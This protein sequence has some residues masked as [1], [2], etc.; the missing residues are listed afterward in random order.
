MPEQLL[1]D[2]RITQSECHALRDIGR[3]V[4]LRLNSWRFSF[5]P[6]SLLPRARHASASPLHGATTRHSIWCS[7]GILLTAATISGEGDQHTLRC[8]SLST[9][10]KPAESSLGQR[11]SGRSCRSSPAA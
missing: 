1:D 6:C 10:T 4:L 3:P 11:R 2:G 8:L 5:H 9:H 7:T